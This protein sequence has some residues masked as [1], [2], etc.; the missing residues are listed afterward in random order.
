MKRGP[1]MAHATTRSRR[2]R[3]VDA[4]D[5]AAHASVPSAVRAAEHAAVVLVAVAYNLA[6]AV[7][8]LGRE[9]MNGA[10]ETVEG[11]GLAAHPDFKTLVVV[12]AAV[13]ALGHL[14]SPAKFDATS[15][16]C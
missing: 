16:P 14:R 12:V 1:G 6:A 8:A 4:I 11:M 10:F 7:L 13:V 15:S 2:G 5:G 9:H 3:S